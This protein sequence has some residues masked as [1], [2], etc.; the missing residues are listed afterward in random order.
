MKVGLSVELTDFLHSWFK[1]GMSSHFLSF[2]LNVELSV[3]FCQSVKVWNFWEQ[4]WTDMKV[5]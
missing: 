1:C 3:T 2:G 5:G 4:P